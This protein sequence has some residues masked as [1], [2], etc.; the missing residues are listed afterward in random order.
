MSDLAIGPFISGWSTSIF[1]SA[2]PAISGKTLSVANHVLLFAA[3]IALSA[4]VR[5]LAE[6][7]AAQNYPHRMDRLTPDQIP[8]S[9]RIQ[10]AISLAVRYFFWVFMAAGVLGNSWQ[11]WVGSAIVLVPQVL[12]W[13]EDEVPNSPT[14]WRLLP[15]GVPGLAF[16]LL[17]TGW[18]TTVL[19]YLVISS[20]HLAK[21]A[22]V[23][24]PMPLIVF[25][26]LAS[27]GRFGET[28]N[29]IKPTKRNKYVYRIGGVVMLAITMRLA[30]IY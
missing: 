20:A 9:S 27:F 5:V 29:E 18:T 16:G 2:L 26:L 1:I 17:V 12:S 14:I 28:E 4:V 23:I 19:S 8:D 21:W 13:Y 11:L 30:G 3:I 15:T 22:F 25:A 10:K 6:E 24:L 7:F